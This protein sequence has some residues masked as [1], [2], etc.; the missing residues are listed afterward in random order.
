MIPELKS[1]WSSTNLAEGDFQFVVKQRDACKDAGDEVG[2]AECTLVLAHVVKWVRSDNHESP[3]ERA[4]TLA[5][6]ALEI[7]RRNQN[8]PLMIDA[9]LMAAPMKGPEA[10][11]QILDTALVLA[12]E[13]GDEHQIAAVLHRKAAFLGLIDKQEARAT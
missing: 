7:C 1:I 11:R 9:L 12:A 8:K 2:Y 4:A 3:F 6:E 5:D 13:L 10:T